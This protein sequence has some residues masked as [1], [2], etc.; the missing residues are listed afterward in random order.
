MILHE[1]ISKHRKE[2][3]ERTRAKVAL[4]AAPRPTPNELTNGIPLFLTQLGRVLKAEAD[5]AAASEMRESATLHGGDLLRQGFTISQ[6]VH[7][8]GDLCQAATELALEMDVPIGTED[9]HTLNRC[10]DNAIA[11]AVT[12]Y[13][14]Q[15][16]VGVWGEE[17]KRLGFFAHELRGHLQT[18]LLAFQAVK[19]GKVGLNGSTVG[20]LERSLRGLRDLIDRS[21]SEVRL[22][23][24][25]YRKERIP[26]GKFIE[27]AEVDASMEATDRGLRFGV[28]HTNQDLLVDVDRQLFSSAI[29][30]LLQNAFKFTKPSSHVWLRTRSHADHVSIEVEDQCGGLLPGTADAIFRPFEQRGA[31]RAGLGLGLAISRQAIE[32]DGGKIWVRDIPGQGCVFVIEMPLAVGAPPEKVI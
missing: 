5:P 24:G 8:Y 13:A 2:L 20:L 10:L 17:V 4:R 25:I 29:S 21:V 11:S 19:S 9:F 30:N 27:E 18:A 23:A 16:D 28:E 32:A 6:V 31:D 1:F 7:D 22:N 3:I 14:R 15:R 12:E 26:L